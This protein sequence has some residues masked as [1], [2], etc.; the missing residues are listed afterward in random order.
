MNL[1]KWNMQESI[2]NRSRGRGNY[3]PAVNALYTSKSLHK[4]QVNSGSVPARCDVFPSAWRFLWMQTSPYLISTPIYSSVFNTDWDLSRVVWGGSVWEWNNLWCLIFSFL[5]EAGVLQLS[6]HETYM[7]S[8]DFLMFLCDW[9]SICR[10]LLNIVNILKKK[11][12]VSTLLFKTCKLI[13]LIKCEKYILKC[14]NLF[15]KY[16]VLLNILFIKKYCDA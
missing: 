3:S 8:A 13:Q 12:C 15:P 11:T 6:L 9:E 1:K 16:A 4:R 7:K 10:N 2:R 5:V 14:Y